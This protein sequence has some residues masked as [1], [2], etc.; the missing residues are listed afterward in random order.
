MYKGDREYASY[1]KYRLSAHTDVQWQKDDYTQE[2]NGG[3]VTVRQVH[4]PTLLDDKGKRTK[5]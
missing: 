1:S 3:E 5:G 2:L 4:G